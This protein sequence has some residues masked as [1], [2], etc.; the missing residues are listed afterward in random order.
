[1]SH[2]HILLR[3]IDRS[4]PFLWIMSLT[5]SCRY[6]MS[7]FRMTLRWLHRPALF[8]VAICPMN[9]RLYHDFQFLSLTVTKTSAEPLLAVKVSVSFLGL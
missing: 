1:M 7:Q 8:V 2:F 4:A 9:S 6:R 5:M 3:W